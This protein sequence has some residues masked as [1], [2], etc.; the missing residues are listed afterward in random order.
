MR[1]FH[2]LGGLFA[3]LSFLRIECFARR[4]SA[5]TPDALTSVLRGVRSRGDWVVLNIVGL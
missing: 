2:S 1:E 5:S 4:V 3:F